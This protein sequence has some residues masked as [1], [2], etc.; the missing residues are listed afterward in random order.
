MMSPSTCIGANAPRRSGGGLLLLTLIAALAAAVSAVASPS[1]SDPNPAARPHA[2]SAVAPT[3]P[4]ASP[5]P[6]APRRSPAGAFAKG[7]KRVGLYGGA[8]SSYSHTY[9]IIGL[10]AGY[11]LLDGFEVGL[12]FEGWLLHTPQTYKLSPQVRY[13][14]WQLQPILPYVGGFYR[15]T[16]VTDGYPDLKSWGGR[17]G[18]AYSSGHGYLALGVVYERYV[19]DVADRDDWYP[20]IGFWLSF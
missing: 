5:T 7:R 19:D 10:G 4:E 18:V 17:A 16:W 20:E 11:Y 12:D 13:V 3:T 8:G 15:K 6:T 9:L 1:Q 14:F 2:G